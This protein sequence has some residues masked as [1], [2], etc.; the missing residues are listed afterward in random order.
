[1]R[2]HKIIKNTKD[3]KLVK[4]AK[5]GNQKAFTKLFDGYKYFILNFINTMIK[6]EADAED[7]MIEVF[8]K[9]F[10]KIQSFDDTYNFST[11]IHR[12]AL[13]K[14]IDYLRA[15]NRKPLITESLI[16]DVEQYVNKIPDLGFSPEDILIGDEQ[17][18]KFKQLTKNMN[19]TFK[20]IIELRFE[21]GK[22]Y[23][24]IAEELDVKIG[25]V[26]A[27]IH[28]TRNALYKLL[29]EST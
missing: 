5:Q 25:T 18:T 3:A 2:E 10:E 23:E 8:A 21:Q 22:S 24:D 13:N 29:T 12:I 27:Q 6:N 26:G 16:Q 19:P 17:I 15:K 28:R 9:A 14:S 7:I 4:E 11:W 1:M 20:R